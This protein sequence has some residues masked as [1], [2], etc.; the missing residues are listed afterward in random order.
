MCLVIYIDD[1]VM[2]IAQSFDSLLLSLA[3]IAPRKL[4]DDER[5]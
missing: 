4:K 2:L 1:Q 3:I 5:K